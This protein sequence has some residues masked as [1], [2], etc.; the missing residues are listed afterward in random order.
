LTTFI[1]FGAIMVSIALALLLWP[2]FRGRV[3]D[4]PVALGAIAIVAVILPLGAAALYRGVSNWEWDAAARQAAAGGPGGAGAAPHSIQEMID[5]LEERL[6][7]KPDDVDGWMM[8]G[9]TEFVRNNYKRAA[10]AF[11]EAYRISGGKNL[12][13]VVG[14]GEALTVSDQSSL[15]NGKAAELF[16][17]ALKLDAQNPKGLWYGGMAAAIGGKL[18]LARERW[19]KLLGQDLPADIKA[20]LVER[21]RE[22]DTQLGRKDDPELA[23]LA[24][25][26][27]PP[28]AAAAPAMGPSPPASADR[29]TAAAASGPGTVTVH[30]K[31]APALAGKIP[32]GAPLFVL[33]RDPSQ[34]GPPF[35]A[36]RFAGAALPMEVVLTEQ[37]AM[38]PGRTIRDAKQ[39]MIV[40]RFSASGM[41]QQASGD[42]YGEVAYDLASGK[43]VDLLIDKQVP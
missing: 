39:L 2:L 37:D 33:A 38:M 9:R 12:E 36:K 4:G 41:P 34:P 22:V 25:A 15:R 17:D 13:A 30:V 1:I 8:L 14:Y 5:K 10:D 29:R 23:K 35:G 18:G 24:A 32:P 6:K 40:A 11:G 43:P 19:I 31:V 42:L 7:A 3:T 28:A 21:I 16:E 20:M 27:P 26:I